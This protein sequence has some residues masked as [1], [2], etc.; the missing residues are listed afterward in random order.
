LAV[1]PD[2]VVVLDADKV[3]KAPVLGVPEPIVPGAVYALLANIVLVTVPV[4]P[5][6]IIVPVIAGTLIVN[7]EAVFG[8]VKL[9]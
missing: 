6:V 2:R 1:P 5:E 9:T 3:V 4:S 8:P 7:V